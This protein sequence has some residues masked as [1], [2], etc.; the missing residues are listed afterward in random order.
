MTEATKMTY[1][2]PATH[3]RMKMLAAS[4]DNRAL[5]EEVE[6]ACIEYLERQKQ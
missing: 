3:K 6:Q 4:K 2:T 5:W 1:L